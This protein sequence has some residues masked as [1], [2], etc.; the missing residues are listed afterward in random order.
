MKGKGGEVTERVEVGTLPC[1]PKWAR[2]LTGSPLRESFVASPLVQF[3]QL[4]VRLDVVAEW[5]SGR[6]V[7]ERRSAGSRE[8]RTLVVLEMPRPRLEQEVRIHL[9]R[10]FTRSASSSPPSSVRIAS[11]ALSALLGS[12]AVTVG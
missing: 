10:V 6:V 9:P 12:F 4:L 1:P 5:H 8:M 7:S 2:E 11:M 3:A